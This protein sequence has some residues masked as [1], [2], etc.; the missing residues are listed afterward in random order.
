MKN[1]LTTLW[2]MGE[3]KSVARIFEEYMKTKGVRR[4]D[5]RRKD[6]TNTYLI[7][8]ES[9]GWNRVQCYYHKDSEVYA[10]EDLEIVL[11]KRAGSYLIIARKGVRAFEVDWNGIKNYDETLLKEI[12]EDHKPLFDALVVE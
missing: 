12:M 10:E 8:G 3:T 4:L 6:N 2:K 5:R 11:R 9:T 1:R 7:D